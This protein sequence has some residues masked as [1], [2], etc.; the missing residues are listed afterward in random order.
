MVFPAFF[1]L[2]LNLAIR[3]SWSEPQSALSYFCW[4]YRAFPSLAAKNIIN[5]ILMLTIWWHS[6]V[7]FSCVL[8]RG[9]LLWPVCF[10]GNTVSLC[11]ASFCTWRPNLPV[12]PGI[13][14]LPT[15]VF[16]FSM[17]RRTCILVLLLDVLVGLHR[18]IQLQLLQQSLRPKKLSHP[19]SRFLD[20]V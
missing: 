8:G 2:S 1:S 4:L 14:W 11:P 12:T 18:I 15:F 20:T 13:S 5:L 16:Q 10:L 17:L 3:S 7:V 9:C 6:C 19:T